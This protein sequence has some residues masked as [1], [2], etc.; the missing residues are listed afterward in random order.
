M[1]LT[2]N[3][4]CPFVENSST[5]LK[6]MYTCKKTGKLCPMVDYSTG[7]ASPKFAFIKKGCALNKKEEIKVIEKKEM[8]KEATPIK[9]IKKLIKNKNFCARVFPYNEVR[10]E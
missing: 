4:F 5:P 1:R 9:E 7:N 2:E 3:N 10:Y 8:K 6:L